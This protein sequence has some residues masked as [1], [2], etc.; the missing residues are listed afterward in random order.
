MTLYY[1]DDMFWGH[2]IE[3]RTD[4]DGEPESANVAG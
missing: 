3:I 2:I 1:Y 4:K